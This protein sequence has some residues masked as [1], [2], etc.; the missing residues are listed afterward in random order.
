MECNSEYNRF[1]AK[2]PVGRFPG[3]VSTHPNWGKDLTPWEF[4]RWGAQIFQK[5]L[6]GG[7]TITRARKKAVQDIVIQVSK[8]DIP[9]WPVEDPENPWNL[10]TQKTVIRNYLNKHWRKLFHLVERSPNT[11]LSFRS[12]YRGPEERPVEPRGDIPKGVL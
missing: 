11:K 5:E 6:T 1:D 3:S 8:D 7:V 10:E 2:T 9:E 12:R 4:K